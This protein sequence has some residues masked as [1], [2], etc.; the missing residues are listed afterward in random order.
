MCVKL[1]FEDLNLAKFRAMFK[2]MLVTSLLTLA[3]Y[4]SFTFHIGITTNT[5]RFFLV[6]GNMVPVT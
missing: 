3:P 1:L 6:I 4:G 5:S 2:A